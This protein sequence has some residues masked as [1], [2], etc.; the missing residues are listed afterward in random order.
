M[1]GYLPENDVDHI[2]RIRD[3][4]RWCNLRHVSR[5]CNIRNRDKFKNNTSGVTGVSWF[6][7]RGT[8]RVRIAVDRKQMG[9]G[10]VFS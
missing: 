10:G 8:W 4:N 9:L 2:N 6:D 7:S 5:V 1:E 3:D